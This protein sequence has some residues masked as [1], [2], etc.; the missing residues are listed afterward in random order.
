MASVVIDTNTGIVAN[1]N[2]AQ[3][4]DACMAACIALLVRT[5]DEGVVLIDNKDLILEEYLA[6]FSPSGQPGPGD[7][8]MN[9]LLLNQWNP[10]YCRR[11]PVT[12]LPGDPRCFAEFPEA[13]D[14]AGF[15]PGDRKWVAVALASGD[16]PAIYNASDTDWWDYKAALSRAGIR[17]EFLCPQLMTRVRRSG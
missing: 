1:G 15:D 7:R 4:D 16:N 14:L 2:T 6:Y 17:I 11:V 8:F 9:W 3:A 10:T 12:P 5:Q 13:P